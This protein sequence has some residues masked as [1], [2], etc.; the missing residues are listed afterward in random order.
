M[1]LV[2]AETESSGLMV[3]IK[4]WWPMLAALIAGVG[5]YAGAKKQMEAR[6]MSLEADREIIAHERTA[7]DDRHRA[8]ERLVSD[9]VASVSSIQASLKMIETLPATL[10]HLSADIARIKG[11]IEGQGREK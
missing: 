1:G 7:A 10:M 11:F 9:T 8:L 4:D 2:M 3:Q 6:I 5:G